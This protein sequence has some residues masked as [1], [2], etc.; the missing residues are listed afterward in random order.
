MSRTAWS[1]EEDEATVADYLAMLVEYHSGQPLNKAAHNRALQRVLRERS[2]AAIEFKHRNI[3]AVLVEDGLD[4]LDGYLPAYNFQELLGDVVRKQ[5]EARP[6]VR[7]L[8][9]EVVESAPALVGATAAVTLEEVAAPR[10]ATKAVRERYLRARRPRIV[11]YDVIEARNRSLGLAGELA[12]LDV[13]ERRLREAGKRSLASRIEHVAKTQGDGLGYDITS[14]ELDGRERLIEV[15][16]TRRA[17]LTPFHVSR[18]EVQVSKDRADF[19]HLY[20]LFRFEREP[21]FFVLSGALDAACRLEPTSF[22]A[23][24]A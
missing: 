21:R 6:A 18:N 17:Q 24:V 19:Y 16:T 11:D 7:A 5:L 4:Y 15:K 10:R 1:P 14:F 9:T 20:R 13:E 12:I 8:I 3:S 2:A 22:R 23:E